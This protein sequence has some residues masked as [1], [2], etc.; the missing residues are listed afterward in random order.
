[1]RLP[2]R[3]LENTRLRSGAPARPVQLAPKNIEALTTYGLVLLQAG[4]YAEARKH[5]LDVQR[6][7]PRLP[8]GY[9]LEA[10]AALAM[11]NYAAAARAFE[12]ADDLFPSASSA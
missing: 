2:I 5:A 9:G 11:Q 10:D 1:L 8:Q 4:Q 12:K 7:F 6:R 3:G